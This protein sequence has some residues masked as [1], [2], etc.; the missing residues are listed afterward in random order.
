MGKLQKRSG[1]LAASGRG[2][3]LAADRKVL[4][5]KHIYEPG[6]VVLD[7]FHNALSNN[8]SKSSTPF[9]S[10]PRGCCDS[11]SD[12]DA[13]PPTTGLTDAVVHVIPSWG[14]TRGCHGSAPGVVD[15][16][17]LASA[18]PLQV[19]SRGPAAAARGAPPGQWDSQARW[20]S[21]PLAAA[22]PARLQVSEVP[23]NSHQGEAAPGYWVAK[24]GGARAC[25]PLAPLG[26]WK[27]RALQVS[28]HEG[29]GAPPG[30][31]Q[32]GPP[33]ASAAPALAVPTRGAPFLA[34]PGSWKGGARQGSG[35][36][37]I[38]PPPGLESS[39]AL[40]D[41]AE[42]AG[43]ARPPMV[44]PGSWAGGAQPRPKPFAIEP[45]PGLDKAPRHALGV[46]HL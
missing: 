23:S 19:L 34:P 25:A 41:R 18:S 24:L 14:P 31:W 1:A 12:S 16:A 5:L 11:A 28:S 46:W 3:T 33:Q 39:N 22:S 38:G 20:S 27:G 26:S 37:V 10:T 2:H 43:R 6:V 8:T 13:H 35:P 42:V 40:P 30:A 7:P 21:G 36:A 17:A 15:G 45:P 29:A 44:P 9:G 4:E 32:G